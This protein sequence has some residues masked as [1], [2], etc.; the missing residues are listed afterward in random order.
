MYFLRFYNGWKSFF[1]IL[2]DLSL[3]KTASFNSVEEGA[4]EESAVGLG[5][6]ICT[7]NT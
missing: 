1:N 7:A 6:E 3:G 2:G 5:V 4:G